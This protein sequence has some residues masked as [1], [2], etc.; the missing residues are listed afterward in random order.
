MIIVDLETTG[1]LADFTNDSEQQPGIVQIGLIEV[2]DVWQPLDR[3]EWLVNPEKPVHLWQDDSIKVHGINPKD[4]I[5][6]PSL[7]QIFNTLATVLRR[8]DTWVGFNNP[9]DRKVL[10]HQ[11][12]RYGWQWRLPWPSKDI[13]I[14][15]IGRDVANIAG[16]RDLKNPK[17]TE[18]YTHLFGKTYEGAHNALADCEATRQ[19][20]ERLH[21]D[22]FIFN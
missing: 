8:H 10:W 13:D 9:F 21:A 14:M 17:L 15:L 11:S 3:H 5:N 6:E 20:G 12:V 18:L 7:P 4:V 22:G 1:L 19:C 16:K 2:N